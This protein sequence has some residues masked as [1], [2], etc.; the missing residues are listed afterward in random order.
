[1]QLSMPFMC[2]VEWPLPLGGLCVHT[3]VFIVALVSML[4]ATG[5]CRA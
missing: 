3:C 2:S 1:M 4:H 5:Y